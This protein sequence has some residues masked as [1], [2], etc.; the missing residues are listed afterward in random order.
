[1]RLVSGGE[2]KTIKVWDLQTGQDART[3]RGHSAPVTSLALSAD[4]KRLFSES[5]DR[6]IKV[7]NL[8]NSQKRTAPVDQGQQ[9]SA[10]TQGDA[11]RCP[12]VPQP[13]S[14]APPPGPWPG[15]LP[16]KPRPSLGPFSLP[17]PW[18]GVGPTRPTDLV[19]PRLSRSAARRLLAA[20]A[21]RRG[22]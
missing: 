4:G 3:L 20:P 8:V 15:S 18:L 13:D 16:P 10:K 5:W 14:T 1:K 17:R 12:T 19:G 6:T 21:P 9:S 2:D 22:P 11:V 7:W